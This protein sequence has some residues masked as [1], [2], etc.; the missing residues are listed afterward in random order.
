MIWLPHAFFLE[1]DLDILSKHCDKRLSH[2]NVG[3]GKDIEIR[4]LAEVIKEV[5]DY[6]GELVFDTSKQ[7]GPA[8]KLLDV[9][10]L[11]ALGWK[12][13]QNYKME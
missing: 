3:S 7:D 12:F 13:Q 2:I 11:E 6:N 5:V 8:R 1:Q 10:K 9:T 4:E